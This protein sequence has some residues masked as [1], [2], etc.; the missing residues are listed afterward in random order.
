MDDA[1]K[2]YRE[3]EETAKEAWRKRDGEDVGDAIGNAGDDLRKE[4]GNAGD[5]MR[6]PDDD[7]TDA[8]AE[9]PL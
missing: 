2:T 3:G 8:D 4:L 5:E 1:K 9:R 6:R 7:V